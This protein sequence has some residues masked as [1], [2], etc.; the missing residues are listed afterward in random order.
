MEKCV[1]PQGKVTYVERACPEGWTPQ[2]IRGGG[3][4]GGAASGAA[5]VGGGGSG[6]SAAKSKAPAGK[7]AAASGA[8]PAG[9]EIRYYDVEGNDFES[10]LAA[11]KA[12]G[13]FHSKAEWKLSYQYQPKRSGKACNPQSVTTQLELS[14]TLPRWTPPRAAPPALQQRW[15]R[16]VTALRRHHDGHHQFGREFESVLQRELTPITERCERLEAKVKQVFG[17]LLERYRQRD[18]EYDRETA[19]GRTQGAEFK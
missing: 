18:I 4:A 12:S 5:A 9:A 1:S 17:V 16:Y 19:H 13:G 10:L 8:A 11:L 6:G 2:T 3:S 15:T 7:A 14:M